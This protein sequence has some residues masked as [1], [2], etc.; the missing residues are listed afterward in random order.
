MENIVRERGR[1]F[2]IVFSSV[3]KCDLHFKISITRAG[4]VAHWFPACLWA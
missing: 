1:I 2:D 3:L 4:G